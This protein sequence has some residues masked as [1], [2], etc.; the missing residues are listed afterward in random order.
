MDRKSIAFIFKM[1]QVNFLSN[2]L[3]H[4]LTVRKFE[5]KNNV[6]DHI[7]VLPINFDIKSRI[8][9]VFNKSLIILGHIIE[10]SQNIFVVI[11]NSTILQRLRQEIR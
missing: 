10:Y 6:I 3:D 11:N 4:V 7:F 5:P 8:D 2:L 9:M 1:N